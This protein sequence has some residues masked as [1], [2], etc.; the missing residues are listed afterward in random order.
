MKLESLIDQPG[1]L[2]VIPKVVQKLMQSFGDENVS[3]TE[4]A[5]Q[6]AADPTL[7]AKLLRLANSAYFH[8]SR[9][10]GSVDD[11]LRML[12]FVMVRNLVLGNGMAKAFPKIP[13]IDL[14]QFWRYTLYTACTARWLANEASKARGSGDAT[15][16]TASDT[17]FTL[18][19]MHGIG[20]LQI[21]VVMPYAMPSMKPQV[22]VLAAERAALETQE[23]GFNYAEV[24]AELAQ[25]WNFP[26]HLVGA[27]RRIP[28]PLAAGEF[29]AAAA[30]VHLA[31][32]RARAEVLEMSS[33]EMAASYPQAV[34][35][36]L[37]I[38][39]D[40]VERMPALPELTAGLAEM[41][42]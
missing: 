25:L 42:E 32:W 37:G 3:A 14:P 31:A 7:S 5:Q 22:H 9:T 10:V 12:G 1:K 23:F 28:E 16:G 2:P 39:D 40:W 41:L 20:Q 8:V 34:A 29:S 30:L 24:S 11:A 38:D 33:D 26:A 6:I 36:R 18:G 27:L 21:H 17:V 19:M 4:I 13:G 35:Q 15:G